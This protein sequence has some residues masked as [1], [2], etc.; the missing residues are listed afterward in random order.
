MDEL[1]VFRHE[2]VLV[3]DSRLIAARL[4]IEHESFIRTIKIYQAQAEQAFGVFR[5][6][7]GEPKGGSKGGRPPEHVLLTEDQATFL[8]TLSRNTP[9]V[10]QCKVDLVKAFSKAKEFL[11]QVEQE[12]RDWKAIKA[13]TLLTPRKWTKM[14][15]DDFWQRLEVATGKPQHVNAWLVKHLYERFPKGVH[16]TMVQQN[17]K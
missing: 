16:E 13:Y 5:F 8:M 9:E 3:V 15:S 7:I 1:S 14:F 6:Q 17:P 2:D 10:V 11:K 12:Q 4:G